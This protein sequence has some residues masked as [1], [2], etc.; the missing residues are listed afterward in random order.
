[1]V[2]HEQF[3]PNYSPPRQRLRPLFSFLGLNARHSRPDTNQSSQY[4]RE[5][6]YWSAGHKWAE[7][8]NSRVSPW[9]LVRIMPLF[10]Q[11][12]SERD[13]K[14]PNQRGFSCFFFEK[15]VRLCFLQRR[16]S[17]PRARE[18]TCLSHTTALLCSHPSCVSSFSCISLTAF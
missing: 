4:G 3:S 15:G 17:A 2:T 5:L 11:A 14:E 9:A 16:E 10:S 12:K 7:G 6:T 8:H 13:E 1:M 18:K